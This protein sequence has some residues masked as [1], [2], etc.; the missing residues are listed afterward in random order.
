MALELH[1]LSTIVLLCQFCLYTDSFTSALPPSSQL[2]N[3]PDLIYGSFSLNFQR[4][5][6]LYPLS[7]ISL[8]TAFPLLLILSWSII[9]I[10][11]Q[12]S[13]NRVNRWKWVSHNSLVTKHLC[14][15]INKKHNGQGM[16]KGLACVHIY[17]YTNIYLYI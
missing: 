14:K 8:L 7:I 16:S 10:R 1:V 6:S 15:Q 11:K 2:H 13:R 9:V 4:D 3:L 17:K 5:I 12:N